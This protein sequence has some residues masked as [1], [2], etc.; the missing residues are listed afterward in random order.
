[1]NSEQEL[2]RDVLRL[3]DEENDRRIAELFG[4][5]FIVNVNEVL[6]TKVPSTAWR[7]DG[8]RAVAEFTLNG[9]MFRLIIVP[10]T[11]TVNGITRYY[12]D[13]GF[14][15]LD[16]HGKELT[17]L[18]GDKQ[19]PSMIMG[20]IING[21]TDQLAIFEKRFELHAIVIGIDR[22]EL[23]REDLYRRM[24]GRTVGRLRG[25][26]VWH[27]EV[28]V[29]NGKLLILYRSSKEGVAAFDEFKDHLISKGRTA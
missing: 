29:P 10:D 6:D 16:E 7:T 24:A 3:T 25:W 4:P 22:D 5:G 15:R 11:Y 2:Y 12:L 26:Q 8:R 13:V 28:S 27:G 20:A 14:A 1:M 9:D 23:D 18:I 17:H 21:L 19:T